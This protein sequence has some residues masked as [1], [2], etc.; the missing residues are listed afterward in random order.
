MPGDADVILLPGSKATLADLRQ[1]RDEG[2][3]V[4]IIA[5]HRRGGLIVG[6]CGGYQ[7]LGRTVADPEG[8]EGPPG[9]ADGLGLLDVRTVLGGDKSLVE[10]Q[11]TELASGEPITGYEMHIGETEGPDRARPWLTLAD[12]RAEGAVSADGR[13]MASYVHGL[14]AADGFRRRFLE[15]LGSVSNGTAYDADVERVLD[16]L[17]VHMEAHLDLDA[18]LDL[19]R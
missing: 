3:D 17:A 11:G 19:S 4:D 10:R 14:F 8:I 1:I 12:G 16:D 6:L 9:K 7:I 13:I 15:R 2:W 5:H 18:L